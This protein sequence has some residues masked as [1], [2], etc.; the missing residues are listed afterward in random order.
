VAPEEKT[1]VDTGA[2]VVTVC[3]ELSGPPQPVAFAVIVDVPV[4]FASYVT[5]PVSESMLLLPEILVA[6]K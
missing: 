1:G 5:V 4:Q 2:F 3:V 6:S